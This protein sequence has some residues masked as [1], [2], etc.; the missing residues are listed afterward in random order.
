[1]TQSFIILIVISLAFFIYFKIKFWRTTATIEKKWQQ[2]RANIAL[3]S[4]L[5]F[6]GLNL[7]VFPRSTVDIIIG[8][9]FVL[10]GLAN[11]Y[12]G[13]Q[14]YKHYLPQVIEERKEKL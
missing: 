2:T 11:A 12:F 7:L 8:I 10:L 1:M 4:F 13:F 3:G 6:F 14:N 5:I 9:I